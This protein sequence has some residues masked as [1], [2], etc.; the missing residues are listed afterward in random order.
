M[1]KKI[2]AFILVVL[3]LALMFVPYGVKMTFAAGP[4]ESDKVIEYFSYF[5]TVPL[6]YGNYGAILSGIATMAAAVLSAMNIKSDMS[7]PV[8]VLMI[9]NINMSLLSWF[10]FGSFTVLGLIIFL[11]HIIAM[12][13]AKE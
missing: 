1:N 7:K 5:S 13:M 3:S 4:E 12:A 2:V 10:I 11:L 9:V 6:G 8:I